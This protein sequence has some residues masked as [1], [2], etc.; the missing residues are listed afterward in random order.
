M[1]GSYAEKRGDNR[2]KKLFASNSVE[3]LISFNE[4]HRNLLKLQVPLGWQWGR[5]E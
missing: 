4:K 5:I 2:K 1:G 3:S